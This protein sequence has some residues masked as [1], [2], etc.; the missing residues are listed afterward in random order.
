MVGPK[1]L[2]WIVRNRRA[3][4]RTAQVVVAAERV[5][6][7]VQV[8]QAQAPDERVR[9]VITTTLDDDCNRSCTVGRIRNGI[10]TIYVADE[11]MVYS[12]HVRWSRL[13][14]ERV[15]NA[16]PSSGVRGVR[17]MKVGQ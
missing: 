9:H 17:F 5:L 10:L 16:Y 13:L 7:Q 4:R 3:P 1:Q 12:Y 8:A 2:G 14:A 11:R 15:H 6:E